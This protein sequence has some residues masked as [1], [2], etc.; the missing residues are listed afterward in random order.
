[1]RK[2]LATLRES[3][4]C[5]KDIGGSACVLEIQSA[6]EHSLTIDV[7]LEATLAATEVKGFPLVSEDGTRVLGG[8]IGRTELM[9]VLG[10]R[11]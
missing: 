1:M 3:G 6:R 5:V 2:D 10:T 8:Y 4:M 7:T 9:Y 11:H